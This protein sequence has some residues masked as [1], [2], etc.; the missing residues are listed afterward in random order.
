MFEDLDTGKCSAGKETNE[1]DKQQ[2]ELV[3][4]C[5]P[6]QNWRN[7]TEQMPIQ[8]MQ[9]ILEII[10]WERFLT[11]DLYLFQTNLLGQNSNNIEI[12]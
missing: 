12:L 9:T 1:A 6:M 5:G 10:S 7:T 11:S 3:F 4:L 8:C 2:G